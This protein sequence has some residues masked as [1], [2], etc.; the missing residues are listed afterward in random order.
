MLQTIASLWSPALPPA[1]PSEGPSVVFQPTHAC[2][3]CERLVELDRHG[4]CDHCQSDA[5]YPA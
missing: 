3:N 2:V 1:P 5:V 4:R